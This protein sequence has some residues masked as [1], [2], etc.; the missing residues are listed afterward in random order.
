MRKKSP[1]P[2]PQPYRLEN[3]Q[4]ARAFSSEADPGS[5]DENAKGQ[6]DRQARRFN[7]T[8]KRHEHPAAAPK[9]KPP[10]AKRAPAIRSLPGKTARP[11]AQRDPRALAAARLLYE[12]TPATL[13]DIS[14]LIGVQPQTAKRY[15]VRENLIRAKQ[16][17]DHPDG[18][19]KLCAGIS[20]CAL[21]SELHAR[22]Y[23]NLERRLHGMEETKEKLLSASERE[24][25]VRS[26][27]SMVRSVEKLH[28]MD[29]AAA[30]AFIDLSPSASEDEA[31]Y[32]MEELRRELSDRL[33]RLH[34]SSRDKKAR[35]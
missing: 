7:Q 13:K 16:D 24:K 25:D 33:A 27:S 12:T 29:R 34:R 32:D 11:V 14:R 8:L 4:F 35:Q 6:K 28:E 10:A 18:R 19:G 20:F 9:G 1:T 3:G 21:R 17:I 5:R 31:P 15:F 26:L 22:L 23:A 2:F 30:K